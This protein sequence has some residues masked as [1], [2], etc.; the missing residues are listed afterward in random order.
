MYKL[1]MEN[2]NDYL[3]KIK[4]IE[5]NL[6]DK[7][8]DSDM[9]RLKKEKENENEDEKAGQ[10]KEIILQ[11]EQEINN[12]KEDEEEDENLEINDDD[13]KIEKK[14][15]NIIKVKAEE[16]LNET[17]LEEK[18]NLDLLKL[19]LTFIAKIEYK[20]D[21]YRTPQ[22]VKNFFKKLY[23]FLN[24]SEK[25]KDQDLIDSIH[26]I[27]KLKDQ[28][29]LDSVPQIKE[30]LQKILQND[31][32]NNNTILNEF[33]NIGGS[34]FSIYNGGSKPFEGWGEKKS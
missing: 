7:I 27:K 9:E 30:E 25:E 10:P 8:L 3:N 1:K 19:E 22:E 33:L 4:T 5:T 24:H 20:W 29:I 2:N 14:V 11:V 28:Q 16:I 26:D 31:F 32:F 18:E 23:K 6:D 12:N 21:V 13:I 15:I 17:K 34:S